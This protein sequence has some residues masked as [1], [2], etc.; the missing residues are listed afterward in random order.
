MYC[1]ILHPE[2]TSNNSLLRSFNF[3]CNRELKS[4]FLKT[5]IAETKSLLTVEY[6]DLKSFLMV[7]I[8]KFN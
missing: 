1:E 4:P 6:M 3:N 7:D 2:C 8:L 5:N